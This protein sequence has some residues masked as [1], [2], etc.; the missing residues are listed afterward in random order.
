[1]RASGGG[2]KSPFWRQILADILNKP[3]VTLDTQEGSAFGA[4][5]L[6]MVGTGA[7]STVPEACRAVVREV[8]SIQPDP[9]NATVYRDGHRVYQALYP[10]LKNAIGW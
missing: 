8:S 6:A 3:V 2:A 4:A 7:F 10:A 9:A 1:M 5:L